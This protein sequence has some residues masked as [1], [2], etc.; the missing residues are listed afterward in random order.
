MKKTCLIVSS[1][2][3]IFFLSCGSSKKAAESQVAENP[4]PQA[5][6][7]EPELDEK[8][9]ASLG[10]IIPL[11]NENGDTVLSVTLPAKTTAVNL[12]RRAE[13][14][15]EYQLVY[16]AWGE[17]DSAK[18]T[19][20]KMIEITDYFVEAG[21]KYDYK[22]NFRLLND[23]DQTSYDQK[24]IAGIESNEISIRPV[25][26]Y[27]DFFMTNTPKVSYDEETSRM[28]FEILPETNMD[29]LVLPEGLEK[30]AVQ[31]VYVNPELY[32]L[33]ILAPETNE[34]PV[35]IT[36]GK[37]ENI[38]SPSDPKALMTDTIL[39]SDNGDGGWRLSIDK[40]TLTTADGWTYRE[41]WYRKYT[42][43]KYGLP[44]TIRIPSACVQNV[45]GKENAENQQI[46]DAK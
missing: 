30:Q 10:K 23:P 25:K 40:K 31:F 45:S 46:N 13:G 16:Q 41:H 14:D 38:A 9:L 11:S 36:L 43:E 27:G 21:K 39:H 12:Y 37:I 7:A 19:R 5:E 24:N 32:G 20:G 6:E 26:G 34:T 44:P 28:T 8:V 35:F 3:S 15:A 33:W 2:L 18:S 42:G 4:E 29:N 22:C 1:L 17:N